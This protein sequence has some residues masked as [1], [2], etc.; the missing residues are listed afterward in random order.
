M[1]YYSTDNYFSDRLMAVL[2]R[3]DPVQYVPASDYE[4]SQTHCFNTISFCTNEQNTKTVRESFF[5]FV[6]NKQ[7]MRSLSVTSIHKPCY[8]QG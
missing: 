1:K 4:N 3:V 2:E 6:K 7:L 8:T 5:L